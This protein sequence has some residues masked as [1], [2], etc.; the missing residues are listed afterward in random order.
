MSYCEC[1]TDYDAPEFFSEHVAKARKQHRCCEC[2]GPILPGEQYHNRTG[3]WDGEVTTYRE[4]AP[5]M[6]LRQWATISMPC[7]CANTFGTLHENAW[8]M[9][10]DIAHT[11][12]GVFFE[13]GRRIV[14]IKRR[15][16]H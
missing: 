4:C 1:D 9:I 12:P 5:C 11:T 16:A 10:R 6:E 8:E 14:K 7:F 15:C 2:G 13:F 3:K